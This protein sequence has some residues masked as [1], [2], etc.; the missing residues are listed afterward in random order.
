MN[1]PEVNAYYDSQ[2]NE[3]VFPAGILQ[4]PFFDASYD[5]AVNYGAIGS[6]HR[7]RDDA[8]VRRPGPQVRRARK[9]E[10][11]VDPGGPE[12]LRGALEVH[13]AAVRLVRL[14]RTARQR[15]ARAR[16][17]DGG[18]RRSPIAYRAYRK[19]LQGKPEPAK[20]DGFTGDQRFFLSWARVWAANMRPEFSKLM[21]NTNPHPL[22]QFRAIGP[23]S[24]MP[25]FA[26]A[27][28]CKS[29]MRWCGVR[30]ARSGEVRGSRQ[31]KATAPSRSS[32]FVKH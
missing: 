16:R 8:R 14:R 19:S 23:P 11:V 7:P 32:R 31:A 6:R 22:D 17:G 18:P 10:R 15:E 1:P 12:E 28:G 9:P 20:I 3:I 30:C 26:K 4:P 2:L 21:L 29:G 27:F 24:S 5:D 13:R 25:E